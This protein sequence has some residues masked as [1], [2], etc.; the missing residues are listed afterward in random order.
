MGIDAATDMFSHS[1]GV[2]DAVGNRSSTSCVE[3]S[4]VDQVDREP[5]VDG[6][7]HRISQD[8]SA[9]Y[10]RRCSPVCR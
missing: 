2:Y 6:I 10:G 1:S 3:G 7:E 4:K 9:D 8:L 5:G